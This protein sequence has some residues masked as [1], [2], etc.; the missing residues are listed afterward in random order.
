[1]QCL[2][3]GLVAG[4]CLNHPSPYN[5]SRGWTGKSFLVIPL[6]SSPSRLAGHHL[7]SFALRRD[8]KRSP[9][10]SLGSRQG[11]WCPRGCSV[12]IFHG[13]R[14]QVVRAQAG[15]LGGKA[16]GPG[17]CL[18]F[19]RLVL[20]LPASSLPSLSSLSS[21]SA[22]APSYKCVYDS[23]RSPRAMTYMSHFIPFSTHEPL[24]PWLPCTNEAKLWCPAPGRVI[25]AR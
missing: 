9:R 17:P 12:L 6:S 8:K 22:A 1:M 19:H 15:A 25:W 11:E 14:A 10:E 23:I 2:V 3:P 4:T 13:C 16:E 20:G 18:S 21:E 7:N 5:L 24:R